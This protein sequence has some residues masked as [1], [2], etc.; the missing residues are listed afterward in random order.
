MRSRFILLPLITS[1][2]VALTLGAHGQTKPDPTGDEAQIKAVID[3]GTEAWNEH[4]MVKWASRFTEDADFINIRGSW[5]RG[6]A[7][8]RDRH[9]ALHRTMFSKSRLAVVDHKIKVLRPDVAVAIVTVEMT[10]HETSGGT[11]RTDYNRFTAVLVKVQEEWKITAFENVNLA[12][13]PTKK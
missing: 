12:E 2:L 7:E 5:W 4:D 9:A 6:R 13:P 11:Y 10:G 1:L 3:L 8:I